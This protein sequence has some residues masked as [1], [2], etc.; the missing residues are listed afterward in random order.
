[1]AMIGILAVFAELERATITERMQGGI[2]SELKQDISKLAEIICLLDT[3]G[4]R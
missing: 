2:K 4:N 1:M 3:K